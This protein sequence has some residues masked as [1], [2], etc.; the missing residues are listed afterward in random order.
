MIVDLAARCQL[1]NEVRDLHTHGIELIDIPQMGDIAQAMLR[2]ALEERGETPSETE[3]GEAV[4]EAFDPKK[5]S[6]YE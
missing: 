6:T 4:R 1:R 5:F 3:V 2:D